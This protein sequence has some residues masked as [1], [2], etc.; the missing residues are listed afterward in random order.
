MALLP[1]VYLGCGSLKVPDE[2]KPVNPRGNVI[3]KTA[4]S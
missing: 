3:G 2:L 1:Y 4:D